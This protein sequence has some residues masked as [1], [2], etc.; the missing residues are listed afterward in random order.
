[1]SFF[2]DLTGQRFGRLIVLKRTDNDKWGNL[3]WLCKCDCGKKIIVQGGNLKSNNTQSC[4]CLHKER[5]STI[6][7][8]HGHKKN[9]EVT[10]IYTAWCHIKQRCTNLKDK[11][12]QDYGGRGIVICSRWKNSFE[13]FLEDM[14]KGWKPK[15]TIERIEKNGDYYPGNCKWATR[16]EQ[17]RNTR[18]NHLISHLGQI[19][20]ISVW[21]EKTGI[22]ERVIWWRIN[23]DWSTEETLTIPVGQHRRKS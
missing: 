11:D 12:Y 1:M 22:S 9:G 10:Q 6:N 18:H 3:C 20:C 5:V 19:Q 7:T 8:I 21:S 14:Q 2:I 23:H 4:G 15:L 17:A 16:K 13:N